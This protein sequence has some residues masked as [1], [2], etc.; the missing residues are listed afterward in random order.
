MGGGYERYSQI[1]GGNTIIIGKGKAD[2]KDSLAD[3]CGKVKALQTQDNENES[4]RTTNRPHGYIVSGKIAKKGSW[5]WMV[6]MTV[7]YSHFCGGTIIAKRTVLTAAHCVEVYRKATIQYGCH[8]YKLD[9][10]FRERA[11][12]SLI[13]PQYR[14]PQ[15]DMALVKL[16]L[17]VFS[18]SDF[19]SPVCL[20]PVGSTMPK[21]GN[22][23]S[24]A[25]WGRTNGGDWSSGSE[26]LK[27]VTY[28]LEFVM[29]P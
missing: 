16:S 7:G 19:V 28:T 2:E 22:V 21:P 4:E 9:C 26:I 20:P 23:F 27:E 25:G 6:S 24:I 1:I 13:H 8:R 15:Y 10:K 18:F 12:V 29:T 14:L 3:E 17:G 11:S 5:P